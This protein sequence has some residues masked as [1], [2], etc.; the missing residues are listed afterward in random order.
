MTVMVLSQ[1]RL[2]QPKVHY[3]IVILYFLMKVM[4]QCAFSCGIPIRRVLHHVHS[5]SLAYEDGIMFMS[6]PFAARQ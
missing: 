6:E 1:P 2:A 3:F 4:G 5:A